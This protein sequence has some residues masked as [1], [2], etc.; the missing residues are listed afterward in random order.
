MPGLVVAVLIAGK[1]HV[2]FSP[3][4]LFNLVDFMIFLPM[5]YYPASW[6][7]KIALIT[8]EVDNMVIGGCWV[9]LMHSLLKPE[10]VRVAALNL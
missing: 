6:G 1:L 8:K 7:E 2:R 4:A 5:V 10:T 3:I 9:S